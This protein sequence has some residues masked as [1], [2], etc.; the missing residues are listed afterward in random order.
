MCRRRPPQ[1]YAS[2]FRSASLTKH[3]LTLI[4]ELA[5]LVNLLLHTNTY[6]VNPVA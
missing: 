2:T 5:L 3:F 6:T 1:P 4:S